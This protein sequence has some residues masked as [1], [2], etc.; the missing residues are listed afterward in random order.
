MPTTDITCDVGF[1]NNGENGNY[2]SGT[3]SILES[4]DQV[5]ILT[6]TKVF[7]LR[8]PLTAIPTGATISSASFKCYVQTD[9]NGWGQKIRKSLST[10][11]TPLSWNQMGGDR[12]DYSTDYTGNVGVGTGAKTLTINSS[13]LSYLNSNIGSYI[14]LCAGSIGSPTKSWDIYGLGHTIAAQKPII[15]ITYT[16]PAPTISSIYFG[17]YSSKRVSANKADI[18]LLWATGTNF[19]ETPSAFNLIKQESPNLG[20]TYSLS[21]TR[22]SDTLVYARPTFKVI[23][24][25]YKVQVTVSGG[26]ATSSSTVEF[27]N[28]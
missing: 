18:R 26:T 10:Y 13:G 4:G 16:L 3:A 24:G 6:T 21:P 17:G 1:W 19:T 5:F 15:S 27:Y 20:K 14:Y 8:F 11:S 25:T 9:Y 23:P 2:N 7:Y 22:S 28:A 12:V